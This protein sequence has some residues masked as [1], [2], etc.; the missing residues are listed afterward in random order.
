MAWRFRRDI[1]GIRFA[2][3]FAA[4]NAELVGRLI[5]RESGK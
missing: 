3:P 2:D 1:E 4:G 5:E